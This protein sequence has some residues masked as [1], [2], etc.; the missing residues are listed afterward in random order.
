MKQNDHF[1]EITRESEVEP[2]TAKV[3][4]NWRHRSSKMRC[5][6]CMWY[7]LKNAE[8]CF[9]DQANFGRCRRHAPTMSGWPA[10]Y[11]QDWCGDH[12][13]DENKA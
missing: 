3:E 2:E 6:T 9:P 12:K 13:L 7:V 1:F 8:R 4:D 11:G 10:V 5:T